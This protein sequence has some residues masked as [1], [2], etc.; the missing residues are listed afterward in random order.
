LVF[1]YNLFVILLHGRL[2]LIKHL[3][4]LGDFQ[5]WGGAKS[6]Q[7]YFSS[8]SA[9]YL[10]FKEH[11]QICVTKNNI[12]AIYIVFPALFQNMLSD[13]TKVKTLNSTC[14]SFLHLIS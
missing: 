13:Y 5:G 11:S 14:L 3:I 12:T 4:M 2:E 8:P 7:R 6:T 1:L 10:Q 9:K